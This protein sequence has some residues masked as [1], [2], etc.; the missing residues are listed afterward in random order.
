M[1]LD[2]TF[3][4]LPCTSIYLLPLYLSN[5]ARRDSVD[6]P[7]P[8][9]QFHAST[10]DRREGCCSSVIAHAHRT[11]LVVTVAYVWAQ[12]SLLAM[13]TKCNILACLLFQI[14]FLATMRKFPR[15]PE[16]RRGR[17]HGHIH[18]ANLLLI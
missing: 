6:S 2:D 8:L 16:R 7:E 13:R 5:Q 3:L 4:G 15:Y 18:I 9:R 17:I 11:S 14:P 12:T 10:V 1:P